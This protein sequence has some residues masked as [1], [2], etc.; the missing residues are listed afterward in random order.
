MR[1]CNKI[2]ISCR[3]SFSKLLSHFIKNK[4]PDKII[5]YADCRFSFKSSNVY[6]KNG[7]EY[8]ST[9]KPNYF[10]MK[11]HEIRLHR[12]NFPKH[13]LVKLGHDKSMTEWE[14]MKS[15]NYDRIWDCGH[16]KYEWNKKV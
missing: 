14:I 6:K 10:Y 7:F 2:G 13:K 12:F 3:G 11:N 9:S 15:M 8:V 1:F 16:L 4:N 5:T